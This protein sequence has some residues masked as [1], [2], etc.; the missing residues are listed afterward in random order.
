MTA[1]E[2]P[3]A[4]EI[5]EAAAAQEQVKTAPAAPP[6]SA[7]AVAAPP[8]V[9]AAPAP[10]PEPEPAP[11]PAVTPAPAPDL[12]RIKMANASNGATYPGQVLTVD[13]DTGRALIRTGEASRA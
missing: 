8:P 12:I 2:A 10:A 1:E 3:K 13:A 9:K 6:P 5:P 7:P 4:A 11:E